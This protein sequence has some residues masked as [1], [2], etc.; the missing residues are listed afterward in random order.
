M[1]KYD[2]VNSVN[3]P[4]PSPLIYDFFLGTT[5]IGFDE[6]KKRHVAKYGE[7]EANMEVVHKGKTLSLDLKNNCTKTF[8]FPLGRPFPKI[9]GVDGFCKKFDKKSNEKD[10]TKKL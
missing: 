3:I 4:A 1:E 10:L 2:I 9:G 7:V 8:V 5:Y 6:M